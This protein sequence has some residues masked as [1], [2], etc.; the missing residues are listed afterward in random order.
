[1]QKELEVSRTLHF[2]DLKSLANVAAPCISVYVPLES[3]PNTTRR[4]HIRLK[5]AVRRAEELAGQWKLAPADF[6]ALVEPLNTITGDSENW[7]FQPE[8]TLVI[9]RSPDVFRAFEVRQHFDDSVCIGHHFHLFPLIP[10]L[11]RQKA[12]FYI[13][14]LSLKHARLLRCTDR[15][16]EEVPLPPDTPGSLED[17]LN[18]RHPRKAG[19]PGPAPQEAVEEPAGSFTSSADRDNKHPHIAN[20][21]RVVSNAVSDTLKDRTAPLVAAGVEHEL[22]IYRDVNTYPHLIENGVVGSPDSLKGAELHGRALEIVQERLKQPV[23]KAL[24]NFEK[25]GGSDRAATD[26]P[27]IIKAAFEGRVAHLFVAEGAKFMGIFDKGTMHV[28]QNGPRSEDLV[29]AAALQTIAYGGD[30]FTL[31][32]EQVPGNGLMAATLRF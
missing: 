10:A 14:A 8:S 29:N 1:M 13:L 30:V 4:E 22:V 26:A 7:R 23:E 20:F 28:Q 17:W 27:K 16:S 11:Q 32:R 18:T 12:E 15:T 31:R 5:S 25:S 9:L 2:D 6:R 3:A 24:A 21:Y 19:N